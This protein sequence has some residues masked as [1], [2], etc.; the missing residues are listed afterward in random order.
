MAIL[1]HIASKNADYGEAERYLIFQYNEYTGK[2]ILDQN[3][4]MIPRE[5]YLIDGIHCN[6][7]TFDIECRELNA[8]CH[9][10]K[11]YD[12]IKSHHYILSFDPRD[13][14]EN[15]LTCERAQQLGI[16]FATKNFPGHQALVCTH[17]DGHNQSGN[18][19]VHIIINSLRKHNVERQDFMERPCDSLA[20]YKH[21]LSKPYLIYL[22]QSLMDLCHREKLH[23]V[24]LLNPARQKVTEKEY[25][26]K[27]R[28]EEKL[29]QQITQKDTTHVTKQ[30]TPFQTQK[31]YL[32]NAIQSSVSHAC[33]LEE[34]QQQLLDKYRVK[35]HIS[36]GRFSYLHPERTHNITGRQLGADYKEDY[37]LKLIQENAEQQNI[38]KQKYKSHSKPSVPEPE[39]APSTLHYEKMI[40]IHSDLR[41][42]VDLQN[43]I[44]AQQNAAYARKVK[45]SNLKEMAKTIA[46]IQENGYDTK[47]SLEQDL[48]KAKTQST[49]A[50]KTLKS[51]EEKLRN[52][53][54]QIHF[55][56]QY[57]ANKSIYAQF[58]NAT[59]KAAFRQKHSAEI[60][61]YET[62]VKILREKEK[63]GKLPSMKLLK[64]EK[65]K[66]LQQKILDK[67]HYQ[68]CQEYQKNL[69]VICHNIDKI[70]GKAYESKELQ[71]SIEL[72]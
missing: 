14:K 20:G 32:R 44:K 17:T 55:T 1:K 43:C 23:Q 46:Y 26:V 59:N 3:K 48:L 28:G 42:V 68:T 31:D 66:L 34:F 57:L 22:K 63:D 60:T 36:R 8:H 10:N 37:I 30:K 41:L 64:A 71:Q 45:L 61:L 2:P 16:E 4:K 58:L 50:R 18:I 69:T 6:P 53:N 51:T 27:R 29:N 72:S 11:N 62:A 39:T 56:G 24:D 25:W 49:D 7:Y 65:E 40:F 15:K 13:K 12:D 52:I 35:L 47:A 21:H 70:L 5:E 54:E 67:E 9:K 33:S 38:R 19:H